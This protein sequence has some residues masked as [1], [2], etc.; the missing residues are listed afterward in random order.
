M[1]GELV[2]VTCASSLIKQLRDRCCLI[3]IPLPKLT[4]GYHCYLSVLLVSQE[5]FRSFL[6]TVPP[7]FSKNERCRQWI[8]YE[9]ILQCAACL[10]VLVKGLSYFTKPPYLSEVSPFFQ[11]RYHVFMTCSLFSFKH[12]YSKN[13][14]IS[15]PEPQKLNYQSPPGFRI[16]YLKVCSSLYGVQLLETCNNK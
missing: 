16:H 12:L 3:S 10:K 11:T 4:V 14:Y 15:V 8:Q 5:L 9:Y 6:I 7:Q 13:Q 1:V 2:P